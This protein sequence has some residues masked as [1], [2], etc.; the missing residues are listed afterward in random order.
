MWHAW[1]RYEMHGGYWWGNLRERDNL[2]DLDID[3]WMI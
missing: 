1:K 2:Q 3:E